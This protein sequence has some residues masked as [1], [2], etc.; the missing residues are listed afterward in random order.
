VAVWSSAALGLAGGRPVLVVGSYDGNIYC[1]DALTGHRRWRFTTGGGVYSAPVIWRGQGRPLVFAAS[2]DRLVYAIDADLGRREWVHAIKAWRPTM[3][4]ARLSS[5]AVGR[6][7]GRPAV[8]VGHWVWDKSLSGHLQAGGLTALEAASGRLLWSAQLG[9]NQISAPAYLELEG[10]GLVLVASENGNLYA[11][12]ADSGRRLWAHTD[13]NAIK[14][15]PAVFSSGGQPR[16]VIGSRFG[17]V[18]CLDARDGRELW[19][20]KTGHWVDGSAAVEDQAGLA[21]IFVG[22]YDGNL[23]ALDARSG[24]LLWSYRTAAGIYSSPALLREGASLRVLVSSWDHHLHCVDG[25]EGRPL[26]KIFTGR[27]LWDSVPLGESLWASPS[28]A[29]IG[30]RAWV[31]LGSYA[32]P[33][34]GI[35]LEEAAQQG[36]ARPGSNRRFLITLPVVMLGVAFLAL[37]LTWRSRRQ[38]Q[39]APASDSDCPDRRAG[40]E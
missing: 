14:A 5:P 21:R 12:E 6:A 10:G 26:W 7:R 4:G 27:P 8:F 29:V 40:I 19:S 39:Q 24:A 35:P 30:E 13:R 23:Y 16:V 38:Q 33:L 25:E 31:F 3:G 22:S 37:L 9:D 11:L 17:R 18:R 36:L 2:S 32:G 20:F 34:H 15:S 28:V 1:L